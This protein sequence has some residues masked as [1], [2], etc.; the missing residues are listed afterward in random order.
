VVRLSIACFVLASASGPSVV[1]DDDASGA[2]TST[3]DGKPP[4]MTTL[5]PTSDGRADTTGDAIAT[6]RDDHD[7]TDDGAAP[8]DIGST[9]DCVQ[10]ICL[11]Q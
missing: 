7:A 2:S 3:A 1:G 9:A 8:T 11:S 10:G 6:S 4:T 5:A